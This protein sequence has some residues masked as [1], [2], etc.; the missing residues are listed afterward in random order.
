MFIINPYR[1][2]ATGPI[3]DFFA[4]IHTSSLY[5]T[6]GPVGLQISASIHTSSVDFTIGPVA[7]DAY[8]SSDEI[9][10]TAEFSVGPSRETYVLTD[11]IN[12][13]VEI[14]VT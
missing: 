9:I 8:T 12:D 7:N 1:Y 6:V 5:F 11:Q 14:I 10:S 4:S 13:T 3:P 2:A